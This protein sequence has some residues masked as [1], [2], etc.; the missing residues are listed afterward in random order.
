MT[1]VARDVVVDA[2]VSAA[3]V[4]PDETSRET[5]QLLSDIM[6][7]RTRLVVPFLWEYEM[8]NVIRGAT[9]RKRLPEHEAK[10]ALH[11][12]SELPAELVS[13][14]GESRPAVF[15][16]ALRH[17]LSI[18]DAAYWTLADARGITLFSADEDLLALKSSFP[19]IKPIAEYPRK[20]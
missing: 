20:L 10:K 19:W 13:L 15:E 5:E 7:H 2:S 16:A 18:Y 3:W 11:L 9:A 14:N 8:L 6:D 17:N 1:P 12:L 4:L